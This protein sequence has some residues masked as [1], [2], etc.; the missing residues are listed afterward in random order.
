M[1]DKLRNE[2]VL[3][4]AAIGAAVTLLVQFGVPITDGQANAITALAWALLALSARGKV[5]PV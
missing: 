3:V 4:R 2:P 5:S 1:L